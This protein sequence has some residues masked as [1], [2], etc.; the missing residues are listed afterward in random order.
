M[1]EFKSLSIARIFFMHLQVIYNLFAIE[2]TIYIS[3]S[4]GYIHN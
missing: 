3:L 2:A 4:L 1:W